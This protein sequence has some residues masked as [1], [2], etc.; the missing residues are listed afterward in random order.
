MGRDRKKFVFYEEPTYAFCIV[1][2]LIALA[3]AHNAFRRPFKSVQELLSL[4]VP[5]SRH[6][7]RLKFRR[8]ILTK[9]YFRDVEWIDF[10]YRLS[11][12][13]AFPYH[14]YRDRHVH[15]CRLVG[16]EELG[17][18]YDLRRGSG[19]N[20]HS[21]FLP[22]ISCS[23]RPSI[24]HY[25]PFRVGTLIPEEA[26]QVM[27]HHGNTYRQYYL[28]DLIERDF[29]SI[30][31]G[32]PQQD[33]LVHA[34]ARM[35]LTWDKRAPQGLTAQQK[36]EVYNDPKLVR[37]RRRRDTYRQRLTRL[38]FYPLRT[39]TSHPDYAKYKRKVREISS[40]TTVL[41]NKRLDQEVRH[42]HD[43]IDDLEIARQLDGRSVA[44]P[45]VPR[46]VEFE[47]AERALVAKFISLSLDKSADT[48]ALGGK[49]TFIDALVRLCH[50]QEG[51][52]SPRKPG[53][54][55]IPVCL[56]RQQLG[57][58]SRAAQTPDRRVQPILRTESREN[59]STVRVLLA[60][61][62]VRLH[63]YPRTM[64][65]SS[66]GSR[67]PESSPSAGISSLTSRQVDSRSPSG[68]GS[69]AVTH[70]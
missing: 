29:S 3:L 30:Y 16:K 31:F 5:P 67:S 18:L 2:G 28:P 69:E 39:A 49:A 46:A 4:T 50:Q 27:G 9:P 57:A 63:K 66:A 7:L 32:T 45:Y 58:A 11:D 22:V 70:C 36:Q 56:E 62:P 64:S 53:M 54:Q 52:R 13:K 65:A 33:E 26:D 55:A 20:L 38:G 6:V 42:F 59:G 34:V 47:S 8:E 40:T 61:W 24:A 51:H 60:P 35:G 19:R 12:D 43:T 10:G 15:L 68:V 23:V 37:L 41:K 1:Y 17:E 14:K 48:E 25:K 44:E 21:E